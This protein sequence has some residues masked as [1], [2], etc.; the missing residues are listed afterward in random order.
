[1]IVERDYQ[2]VFRTERV[3]A[4][5]AAEIPAQRITGGELCRHI[6]DRRAGD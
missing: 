3:A 5:Q 4:Q 2:L 6:A 1:V